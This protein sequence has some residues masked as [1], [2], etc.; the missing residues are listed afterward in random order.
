MR[1][2][3]KIAA[4]SQKICHIPSTHLSD[5]SS[6]LPRSITPEGPI[7]YRV[8]EVHVISTTL[9]QILSVR[10]A[11][12]KLKIDEYFAFRIASGIAAAIAYWLRCCNAAATVSL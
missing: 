3:T 11:L 9:I 2:A 1:S 10:A 7:M 5:L 8:E 4:N 6:T 12:I